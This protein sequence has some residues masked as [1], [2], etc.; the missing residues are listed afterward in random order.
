MSPAPKSFEKCVRNRI[1][2]HMEMNNLYDNN[3]HVFK[4]G[5]SCLSKLLMP[6]DWLLENLAEGNNVD[7]VFLDL[8]GLLTRLTMEYYSTRSRPWV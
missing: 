4:N 5:Q 2:T 3:Q 1:V 8:P 6:F 7:M